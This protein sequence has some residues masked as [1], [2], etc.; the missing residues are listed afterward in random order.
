MKQSIRKAGSKLVRIFPPEGRVNCLRASQDASRAR[1]R[2]KVFSLSEQN[3]K[4]RH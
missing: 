2:G 1:L 4:Y 3:N